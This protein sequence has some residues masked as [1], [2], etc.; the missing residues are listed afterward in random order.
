M[1]TTTPA[2]TTTVISTSSPNSITPTTTSIVSTPTTTTTV[3]PA[4]VATKPARSPLGTQFINIMLIFLGSLTIVIYAVIFRYSPSMFVALICLYL[5]AYSLFIVL[6]TN[7][8]KTCF[9]GDKSYVGLTYI[10]IYTLFFAVF[11]FISAVIVYFATPKK[12]ISTF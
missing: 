11:M 3:A 8:K 1:S 7:N 5:I 12:P 9:E 6:Y 10:T 2:S 4:P